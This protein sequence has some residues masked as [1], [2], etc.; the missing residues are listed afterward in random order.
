VLRSLLRTR[1]DLA[2][3]NLLLRQQLAVALRGHP[4][5][6]L[7]RR[8]RLFWM[9]AR[10]VCADWRRHLV[11]VRPETVL[12]WHRRGWRL[13]WWWRSRRP[14]GRPRV[15]GEVRDLIARMS[16]DNPLWGTVRIRG[17][18]LKLGIAVSAGSVRRYRWREPA[19][20]PGQTWRTFLHNHA[21]QIWA[22]DL[23]TV[24]TL[25]FRTLYILLFISHDRRALVHVRATGHPTAAWVWQQLVEATPWGRCPKYLVRDRDAVYG[26]DFV[27]RARGRGI[28]TLLTPFRAPKANAIAE[29]VI[30]TLRRECLDHVLIVNEEHLQAVLQEYIGY[31]N[32]ERPHRSLTLMPP[33]PSARTSHLQGASPGH[34]VVRPIL[35][36]LHHVYER[37]A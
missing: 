29:R 20:P 2:L 34:V 3:E 26:R 18:L 16:K 9:L 21:H 17:E 33:R 8:D 28:E 15:P 25:T 13:V 36:G 11:L 5:P 1:R 14:T 24:P 31:Y 32:T 22:A 6:R 4:P 10:R 7:R 30:R 19:R 12:R 23:F 37:A 35:G 27:A